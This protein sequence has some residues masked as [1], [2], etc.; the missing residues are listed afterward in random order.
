SRYSQAK[1]ELYGLTVSLKQTRAWTFGIKN[2][3]VETDASYIK[4]MLNNPDEIPNA[5]L[6]RWIAYIQLFSFTLRHIPA[7][8]HKAPDGL[9]RRPLA[10]DEE[11]FDSEGFD[12]LLDE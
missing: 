12:K 7:E 3:V 9:S 2:F 11:P 10:E 6:N 1:I 8:R 4:G 5:T